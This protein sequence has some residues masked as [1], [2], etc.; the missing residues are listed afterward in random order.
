[1]LGTAAANLAITLG[2]RGGVFIGGGIVPKLGGYFDS[3]PF[4]ARFEHKGRFSA[5]LAAVPTC[6]ITE[7]YPAL[8]GLAAALRG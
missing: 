1:V 8:L 7:E 2:A 5:Y 6:V 4:R 3:S